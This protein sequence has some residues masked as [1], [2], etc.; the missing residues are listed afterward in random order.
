MRREGMHKKEE[1]H[2]Q[3]IRSHLQRTIHSFIAL[4]LGTSE[5]DARKQAKPKS[6]LVAERNKQIPYWTLKHRIMRLYLIKL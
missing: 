4:I 5:D 6:I 1:D 3:W 2:M